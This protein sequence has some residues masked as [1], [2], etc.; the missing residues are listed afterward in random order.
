MREVKPDIA[1]VTTMSLIEDVKE[2]LML[3]AN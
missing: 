3:C 2:A 1:I